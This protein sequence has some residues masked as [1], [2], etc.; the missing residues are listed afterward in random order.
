MKSPFLCLIAVLVL[1]TAQRAHAG[2]CETAFEPALEEHQALKSA[3]PAAFALRPG[4]LKDDPLIAKATTFTQ[5]DQALAQRKVKWDLQRKELEA[6]NARASRLLA[7]WSE[8]EALCTAEGEKRKASWANRNMREMTNSSQSSR[9]PAMVSKFDC[10]ERAERVVGYHALLMMEASQQGFSATLDQE[11]RSRGFDKPAQLLAP[12]AKCEL[13]DLE[14]FAELLGKVKLKIIDPFRDFISTPMPAS[15]LEGHKKRFSVA[16][17][18]EASEGRLGAVRALLEQGNYKV[19]LNARDEEDGMNLIMAVAR[20][21]NDALAEQVIKFARLHPE[22]GSLE[23][24]AQDLE[25]HTALAYCASTPE[26]KA[27]TMR[28]LLVDLKADK[29]LKDKEGLTPAAE[30]R[31]GER[32]DLLELL[33]D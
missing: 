17:I 29:K 10:D 2:P 13:M 24:N 20:S 33:K 7:R 5:Y 1:A 3:F 22:R 12:F 9:G 8:I 15:D 6:L 4:A 21:G 16:L 25:G 14:R 28:R 11:A 18:T 26:C 30:A 27:V 19:P 23:P 31:K 32:T